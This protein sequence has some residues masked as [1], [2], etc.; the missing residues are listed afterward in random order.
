MTQP[1]ERWHEDGYQARVQ[2]LIAALQEI[3]DWEE[4]DARIDEAI[5]QLSHFKNKIKMRDYKNGS[6]S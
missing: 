6:Q 3:D 4:L 1:H 2:A 5:E